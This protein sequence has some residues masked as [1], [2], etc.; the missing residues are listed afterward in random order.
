ME[1]SE[2]ANGEVRLSLLRD[3][4]A[5]PEREW[6][7]ALLYDIVLEESGQSVGQIDLRLGYTTHVVKYGG[8]IGYGVNEDWRGHGFA[9]SACRLVSTVAREHG[10]DVIWITCDPE[11]WASRKTCEA[12]GADLVEIVDL[13]EGC[14]LYERGGRQ[15]CR[16]RWV[17]Y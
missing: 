12:V 14:D 10:M 8:H 9:A 13:P 17:L 1:T 4:E 15:V 16:Y 6:L 2:L 5:E 3:S 11:N 7:R